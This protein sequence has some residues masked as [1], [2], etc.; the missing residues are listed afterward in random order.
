MK[1]RLPVLMLALT[2]ITT[3]GRAKISSE[4][5]MK[6]S[7]PDF[8]DGGKIP[9]R[10]TCEGKDVHVVT[11]ARRASKIRRHIS[12]VC[13]MSAAPSRASK[14]SNVCFVPRGDGNRS[15][16]P[17][18]ESL[19]ETVHALNQ[20]CLEMQTR[21]GD[22]VADR[23]SKLRDDHLLGLVNHIDRTGK[24]NEEQNKGNGDNRCWKPSL[25]IMAGPPQV[26]S[27][28][29]GS[30]AVAAGSRQR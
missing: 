16:L 21:L 15:A 8:S 29:T 19:I 26:S 23:F 5:A 3:T 1:T 6:L 10:F 25:F 2:L 30:E 24:E 13:T 9:E 11:F 4:H 20:W 27:R 7:S 14:T 18:Q 17:F 22:G 28:A 12:C